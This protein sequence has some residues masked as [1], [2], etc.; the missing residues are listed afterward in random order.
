M[1]IIKSKLVIDDNYKPSLNQ[2]YFSFFQRAMV[3]AQTNYNQELTR[4]NNINF[5]KLSPIIFFEEY[6]WEI[7]MIDSTNEEVSSYIYDLLDAISPLCHAFLDNNFIDEINPNQLALL[8]DEQ[9]IQAIIKTWKIMLN[10]IKL[11][12]WD[13]YKDN[14]LS[15]VQRLSILPL[16]NQERAERL[17]DCICGAKYFGGP[18]L[19]YLAKHWGFGDPLVLCQNIQKSV[20]MKVQVIGIILLY[21][22]ITFIENKSPM[23]YK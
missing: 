7:C 14:F 5:I 9:K 22:F 17:S 2:D 15:S 20:N 1:Q 11:F 4:V 23:I 8:K 16:M 12:Y 10:G 21:A 18:R 3:F 6:C 13:D 19:R